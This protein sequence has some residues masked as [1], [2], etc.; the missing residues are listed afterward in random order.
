[1]ES[2]TALLALLKV[3]ADRGLRSFQEVMTDPVAKEARAVFLEM[4][5]K[6][7]RLMSMVWEPGREVNAH[8]IVTGKDFR[9]FYQTGW[10]RNW[11]HDDATIQC[12]DETGNWILDDDTHYAISDLGYSVW[13][14]EEGKY[15]SGQMFPVW[16][17]FS[18]WAEGQ[19]PEC[20]Q[21]PEPGP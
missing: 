12:E 10:N 18:D 14:G 15:S 19:Q 21:D 5:E 13:Q 6:D 16:M 7:I 2:Q 8:T 4:A 20:A 9:T 1:M 11:Y 3:A 17:Q